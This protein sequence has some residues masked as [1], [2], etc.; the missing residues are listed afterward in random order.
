MLILHNN[1]QIIKHKV[2]LL[3]LAKVI[4]NVSKALKI[5]NESRVSR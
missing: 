5:M 4:S 2:A 3:N 1:N